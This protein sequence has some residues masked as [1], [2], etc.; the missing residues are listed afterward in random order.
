M[1]ELF[2]EKNYGFSGKIVNIDL[3]LQK[4]SEEPIKN[5]FINLFL[6]GAGYACRY[7]FDHIE[8]DTDPLSKDNILFIMNGLF[9]LTNAPLSSRFVICAKSP[10]TRLW[11]EANCG[12]SFGP[13]LKKAGFDG[14]IIKGQAESPI[15]ICIKEGNIELLDA[16]EIWGFGIKKTRTHLKSQLDFK[17]AKVLCIGQAGEN[18]VKFANINAEGRSAGRTGMG[19]VMGSKNLKAI[20]VQGSSFKPEVA[21]PKYFKSSVK[22]L[23]RHLLNVKATKVLREFGTSATV[24]G[25]YATGDLPIKYWSKGRWRKI[26]DISG[27]ELKEKFLV[28][29]KSCY[30]CLIG[31]G[32]II[33][34]NN[35]NYYSHECEGPE[36]ETIAGFGSMILNNNLE[37][38]AIANDMCNDYGLDTI[39]TSGVISLTFDLFNKNMIQRVDID[40][41]NLDWGNSDSVLK[42]IEKIAKKDGIGEIMAEGSNAVG[43]KFNISKDSIATINN[44]EVPYHDMRYCHGMALT[45]AYS[46]RGPCHTTAD[47]FKVFRKNNEVDFSCL[48]IEKIKM[49]SNKRTMVKNIIKLQNY[50]SIY[51]SLIFCFFSNP[52]PSYICEL[53]YGL[54]GEEFD[55]NNLLIFGERIFNLKRLFNIK[56]GLIPEYESIPKILLDPLNE[57]PIKSMSPNFEKLKKFYYRYRKWNFVNG[58]PSQKLLYLLKLN[59]LAF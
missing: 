4:I 31:C 33:N 1:I 35:E 11:G 57:G 37:S 6:G 52:P 48:G 18:L 59:D 56:M 14:I 19:A 38:I 9:T 16:R 13:E 39:S 34:I 42:L 40:N 45:Y 21:L 41:L 28:R 10:Y 46:P 5:E 8:K 17:D 32:R 53:L 23:I 43:K 58:R 24:L 49:N 29:N 44:M 15:M 50:R 36:Y 7:L 25:A 12:G 22:S 55:V 47:G 2:G 54:T 30:G 26:N 27:E 3:S 20:C 51:S